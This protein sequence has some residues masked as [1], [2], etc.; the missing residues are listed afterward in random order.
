MTVE[1][2]IISAIIVFIITGREAGNST[3]LNLVSELGQTR[4]V[5]LWTCHW[6]CFFYCYTFISSCKCQQITTIFTTNGN[7]R[8]SVQRRVGSTGGCM[9]GNIGEIQ[10]NLQ[11]STYN[12]NCRNSVHRRVG[13]TGGCMKGNGFHRIASLWTTSHHFLWHFH[14][15]IATIATNSYRV[16]L[17]FSQ[18]IICRGGIFLFKSSFTIFGVEKVQQQHQRNLISLYSTGASNCICICISIGM[19][20]W[21]WLGCWRQSCSSRGSGFHCHQAATGQVIIVPHQYL[22]HTSATVPHPS[23]QD[24]TKYHTKPIHG[25]MSHIAQNRT[26]PCTIAI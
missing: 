3:I 10:I 5:W 17:V 2:I 4:W 6:T 12:G 22:Y 7:C 23:T 24:P 25:A 1:I 16:T 18:L 21:L 26:K 11:T 14:A 19:C 20:I 8:K 15:T 13:S 9:K